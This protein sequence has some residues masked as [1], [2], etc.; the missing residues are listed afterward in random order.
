MWN[1]SNC[2]VLA[3]LVWA[4]EHPF[5]K[6]KFRCRI[7]FVF[8]KCVSL[9]DTVRVSPIT[10]LMLYVALHV[11]S[12]KAQYLHRE[13]VLLTVANGWMLVSVLMA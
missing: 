12:C 7:A 13:W 6:K 3:W 2:S 8:K 1:F 5:K 11:L 9:C 10:A 4:T